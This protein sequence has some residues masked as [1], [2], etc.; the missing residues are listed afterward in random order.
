L[1]IAPDWRGEVSQRLAAHRARRQ[2]LCPDS[3]QSD[4][5]FEEAP[6]AEPRATPPISFQAPPT[7]AME[8]RRQRPRIERM[9]IDLSQ[10]VLDFEDS[11]NP[12]ARREAPALV[13]PVASVVE[14]R[15]A[16]FLDFAL[17]L[18]AYGGFLAIFSALGGRWTL[19]T[20]DVGV[21]LGAVAIF[22][23][24]YFAL[25]MLFGGATPGMRLRGLRVVTFEGG[26]PTLTQL[27]WRSI[28][29]F[30]SGATLMLGFLWA[31][32]DDDH[33]SW[34]DRIS[35][36]CITPSGIPQS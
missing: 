23:A 24:Q 22:Y 21:T 33:L 18:F 34:H 8:P 15:R 6:R 5:P 4:L 25:F 1:A 7:P 28:G 11:Q 29:Y 19:S 14:R 32:W 10:P 12:S 13:A 36:T 20:F 2:K 27:L 3:A 31:F 35:K 9:E 26:Q 30:A 17:L 16:A